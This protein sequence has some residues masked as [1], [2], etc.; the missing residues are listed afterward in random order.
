MRAN[1]LSAV[2]IVSMPST[3]SRLSSRAASVRPPA[4][5][6]SLNG[7]SFIVVTRRRLAAPLTCSVYFSRTRVPLIFWL[8]SALRKFGTSRSISS[9]YEDSAGVFCWA[10]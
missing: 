10:L 6:S 9:K 7:M 1:R 4:Y 2:T 3:W 5:T 8:L